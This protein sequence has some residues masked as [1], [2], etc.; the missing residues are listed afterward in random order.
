MAPVRVACRLSLLTMSYIWLVLCA[1]IPFNYAESF[2]YDRQTLLD[3]R[4]C[5]VYVFDAKL[6][7]FA[8]N[9]YRSALR[10]IPDFLRRWPLDVIPRKRRRRRGK[11][12][13]IIVRLKTHLRAG[14]LLSSTSWPR[15]KDLTRFV[16]WHSP[17][18]SVYWFT[19]TRTD[20]PAPPDPSARLLQDSD[21]R[22]IIRS[23]PKG[24]NTANLR[25]FRKASALR[26]T[27]CSP[28]MAL[29]N[30]HSLINKI[31][32]LNDFISSYSLDFLFIT[33]TWV[34]VGDLSPYSELVPT[35]YCFYNSPR[36][37]GRVSYHC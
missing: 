30:A 10:D 4:S 26:S 34:K 3:I 5:C 31:F 11:H 24:V 23:R 37:L 17:V 21:S 14:F 20:L 9:T 13:G 19:Y 1:L 27:L 15:I 12:S 35:D 16:I 32:I 2:V 18:P 22:I 36:P 28:K 33:E 6:G 25:H 7:N 8:D 29:I